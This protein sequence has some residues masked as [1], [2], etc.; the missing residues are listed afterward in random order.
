MC[1]ARFCDVRRT[2]KELG[3]AEEFFRYFEVP[4]EQ[5]ELDVARLHILKRMAEY[6][7]IDE[8]EA[9]DDATLWRTCK[10]TLER[11]YRDF[12][13]SSP[14]EQRGFKVLRR[15]VGRD[16]FVP[17]ASLGRNPRP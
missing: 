7:R 8:T 16:N 17:L 3:S 12:Q 14:L 10:D 15:A 2:L 5:R 11:A 1:D 6:L 9:M 4:F 13:V